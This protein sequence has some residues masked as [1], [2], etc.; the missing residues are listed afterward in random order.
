MPP[1]ALTPLKFLQQV[2]AE[3]K[4]LLPMAEVISFPFPSTPE[5]S[6]AKLWKVLEVNPGLRRFIPDTWTKPDKAD[7]QYIVKILC[8][9]SPEM[10]RDWANNSRQARAALRQAKQKK[11]ELV[12]CSDRWARFLNALPYDNRKMPSI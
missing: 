5:C 2:I 11:F 10:M 7:R 12:E 6:L 4:Q 8:S 3:Q 1:K 9:C